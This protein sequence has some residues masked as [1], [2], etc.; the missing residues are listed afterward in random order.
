MQ[1]YTNKHIKENSFSGVH[2]TLTRHQRTHTGVK[3]DVCNACGK[4]FTPQC[5]LTLHQRIHSGE[6]PK[7]CS[8]QGC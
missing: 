6:K 2:L 4:S 7:V 3:P 1:K 8:T 5:S